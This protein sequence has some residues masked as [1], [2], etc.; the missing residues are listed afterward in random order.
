M[1]AAAEPE[2]QI[3]ATLNCPDGLSVLLASRDGEAL[4][5]MESKSELP[6]TPPRPAFRHPLLQAWQGQV[7][8][9]GK[10][11]AV[12]RQDTLQPLRLKTL[13][14]LPLAERIGLACDILEP[15][16]HLH[17]SGKCLGRLYPETVLADIHQRVALLGEHACQALSPERLRQELL[18]AEQLLRWLISASAPERECDPELEQWLAALRDPAAD[19][20]ACRRA[21]AGLQDWLARHQRFNRQEGGRAA[22]D[23]LLQRMRHAPDFPAL[24]QAI[25]AINKSNNAD[26]ERLQALSSAILKDVSLTNK[27]LKVV[28]SANFSQ[29]G[30]AVSTISRAIVILGFDTI[31]NLALSLLLFE[32][33]H[34]RAHADEIRDVAIKTLFTG[35]L[36]RSLAS[37]CGV[38]EAEEALICGMLQNL[39][40]L[41]CVNYFR[42][43]YRQIQMLI[44]AGAGV[45]QAAHQTL[46]ADYA[47][48]GAAT[49]ALWRFPERILTGMEPMPAGA[50]RQ[51]QTSEMRMKALSSLCRELVCQLTQSGIDQADASRKLLQRYSRALALE[52]APLEQQLAQAQTLLS[53]YLAELGPEAGQGPRSQALRQARLNKSAPPPA[54]SAPPPT[55]PDP[56]RLQATAGSAGVQDI[57]NTLLGDYKLNDL[58]R[59]ILETMY[60]G[61]GFDHALICARSG[62]DLP[63]QARFGFGEK[64]ELLLPA[65]RADIDSGDSLFRK[66]LERNAD[67]LIDDIDAPAIAQ[68]IPAW[69]RQMSVAH[70]FVL[71]P[72]SLDKRKLGILYG[73]RRQAGSLAIAPE[74]LS[75]LKTLRNQALLAIRQQAAR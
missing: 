60:R 70:T 47:D 64:V 8:L 55:A 32:H 58:L 49:A 14:A 3:V 41:L 16:I 15:L 28:N 43:E 21:L 51:P 38:R 66:A 25:A 9:D 12:Y 1:C 42:D 40:E 35:L 39:G 26:S 24:S 50:V 7:R 63:L 29:Y 52:W 31:R 56:T 11:Y 67:M 48:L 37:A 30:G 19:A 68:H 71:L 45:D 2:Y 53:A 10:H 54:A 27:L 65:L 23:H 36:A 13:Q 73:D 4:A 57:T 17:A 62:T 75:L 72:L 69:Y 22:L 59:I 20:G 34:N 6:D 74:Q 18:Q 5:L 44:D 46:G 61:L 33:L